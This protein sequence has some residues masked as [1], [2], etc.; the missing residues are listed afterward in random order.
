VK[1]VAALYDHALY[2]RTLSE[3]TRVL[4]T[5]YEIHTALDELADRVTAVLGLAGS[6]VSLAEDERL[7]FDTAVGPAVAELERV[8]ERLQLGPC[9]TAFH[10]GKVVAV[11]DLSGRDDEWPEYC[12]T[13][14]DLGITAVASMPLQLSGDHPPVGALNLYADGPRSWTP[15]DLAAARVLA[16]MATAYLVNASHHQQQVQLAEQLQ[17]ALDS[18]VVIEQAKG[19]LVARHRIDPGEAFER[20]RCQARSH[21][22]TVLAVATEVVALRLDL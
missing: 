15:E 6:G 20:I 1:E 13:A 10:T 7:E 9:V 18:R 21:N 19:V 3:F 17:R 2:L 22:R 5:P 8:Q 14:A 12:A 4:L 11:D 16:D